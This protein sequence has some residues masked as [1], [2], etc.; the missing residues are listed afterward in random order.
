MLYPRSDPHPNSHTPGSIPQTLTGSLSR[1]SPPAAD[2]A[3]SPGYTSR[4]VAF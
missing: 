3:F 4:V 2:T 1:P